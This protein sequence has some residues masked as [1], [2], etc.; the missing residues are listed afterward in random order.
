MIENKK[1]YR[2]Y[3]LEDRKALGRVNRHF[4]LTLFDMPL[5]YQL[6][7]RRAEYYNNC[8]KSFWQKPFVLFFLLRH[9]ILGNKCGYSIPLNTCGK[10]LNLA[11][12][13]T[14]VINAGARIGEYCRIHVGVN[15]GTAAG[16]G[17]AAPK[18]GNNVYIAP[19]A[20]IFGPIEIADGIAIGANAVVNKSFLTPN[21][22]IGGIPAKQI[23][24]KGSNGFLYTPKC[25]FTNDKK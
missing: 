15:I 9:R 10:G 1:D 24:D 18:I 25:K 19:G 6:A 16:E 21:I 3:V 5:R 14:V 23:S 2:E 4:P 11:H 22:S 17:N 12:L 13:G 7:L 8:C 20:K